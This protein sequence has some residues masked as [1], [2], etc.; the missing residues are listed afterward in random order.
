MSNKNNDC[1]GVAA[2]L[3]VSRRTVFDLWKSGAL[4]SVMI[5]RRRFSTDRQIDEYLARLEGAA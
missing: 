4:P 2:R 3:S 5:G 1:L